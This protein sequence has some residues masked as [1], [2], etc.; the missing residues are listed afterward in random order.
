MIGAGGMIAR[1]GFAGLLVGGLMAAV[2]TSCG[3]GNPDATLRYRMTVTVE[4]PK[5]LRQNSTVRELRFSDGGAGSF[6]AQ[7]RPQIAIV[8]EAVAVDLPNG[9]TL[10][11]LLTGADGDVDYAKRIADRSGIWSEGKSLTIGPVVE[12]WPTA[13]TRPQLVN[14]SPVP[15]FV[16]FGDVREPTSIVEVQPSNLVASFGTGYRL[17]SVT[18]QVTDQPVTKGIRQRL[19]WLGMYPEPR[20]DS[21]Y[22][23]SINP[24]FVQQRAHGDFIRENAK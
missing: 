24:S 9:K 3:A 19:T 20:L 16:T 5:G 17:K 23:G 7:S 2:L 8:G 10:F 11:A 4:T 13:P 15:M 1:R 18:A 22:V 6:F 21:A 12:L 14:T